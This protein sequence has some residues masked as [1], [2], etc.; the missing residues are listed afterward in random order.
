[1]IVDFIIICFKFI[2]FLFLINAGI[3]LLFTLIEI[4]V[5]LKKI[6]LHKSSFY[7]SLILIL[8]IITLFSNIFI[9]TYLL[10]K[11]TSFNNVE[12][13][14]RI[15]LSYMLIPLFTGISLMR[16][17][18][19]TSKRNFKQDY[20]KG[21][22]TDFISGFINFGVMILIILQIILLIA[23]SLMKFLIVFYN[24]ILE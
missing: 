14:S 9:Y 22:V 15:Q 1:M 24:F 13:L 8:F 16:H 20:S 5:T 17:S 18:A 7:S 2:G 4:A 21:I 12:I 11:F 19:N 6:Q 10:Q 23:P 3:A